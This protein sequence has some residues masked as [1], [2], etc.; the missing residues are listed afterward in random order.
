MST[1][2]CFPS[3][4]VIFH[5]FSILVLVS[6]KQGSANLSGSER[7]AR[8]SS[9]PRRERGKLL[10]ARPNCAGRGNWCPWNKRRTAHP[11]LTCHMPKRSK[12]PFNGGAPRKSENP[13]VAP[14]VAG[15]ASS[16]ILLVKPAGFEPGTNGG[17]RAPRSP[18]SATP[19]ADEIMVRKLTDML[20]AKVGWGHVRG[21]S[22]CVCVCAVL[23]IGSLSMTPIPPMRRLPSEIATHVRLGSLR[24][25]APASV[26]GR[27]RS[28]AP[29][30]AVAPVAA[31]RF[32][33]TQSS[34]SP[35][36]APNHCSLDFQTLPSRLS[37][38]MPRP[39]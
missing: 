34:R 5:A 23:G 6:S 33:L 1:V 13:S 10:Y 4:R 36:R 17:F 29:C 12:R 3:Y 16:G 26:D 19:P 24:C 2:L 32:P 8:P 7:D 37:W 25:N 27:L 39:A 14:V 28:T 9:L 21:V 35:P 11:R 22:V 20:K 38:V 31:S 18:E 30:I 15:S